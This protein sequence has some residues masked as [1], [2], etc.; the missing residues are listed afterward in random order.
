MSF[1]SYIYCETQ[2][3]RRAEK[4]KMELRTIRS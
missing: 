4:R 3:G 2:C 1:Q